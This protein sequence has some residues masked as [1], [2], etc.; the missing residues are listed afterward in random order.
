MITPIDVGWVRINDALHKQDRRDRRRKRRGK[1][2]ED[3]AQ[4][5]D[6]ARQI[7][8][9]QIDDEAKLDLVA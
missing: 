3:E 8:A 2:E 1:G 7:E 9:R 4:L 6:E 5:I